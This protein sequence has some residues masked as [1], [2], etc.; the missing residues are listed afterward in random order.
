M[1]EYKARKIL[2]VA[3]WSRGFETKTPSR[4]KKPTIIPIAK[5][6]IFT[7]VLLHSAKSELE[8]ELTY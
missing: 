2:W 3:V 4:F 6:R 8:I 5:E 1:A 7:S